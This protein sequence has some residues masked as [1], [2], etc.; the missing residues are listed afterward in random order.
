MSRGYATRYTK[1]AGHHAEDTRDTAS[2]AAYH[3]EKRP[4]SLPC[5]SADLSIECERCQSYLYRKA[6]DICL[7]D[8]ENNMAQRPI[9]TDAER[10]WGRVND[11]IFVGFPR[12]DD[13]Y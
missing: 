11:D 12:A 7:R 13:G 1:A 2:G 6:F 8:T 9:I 3:A 5:E 4:P 10:S